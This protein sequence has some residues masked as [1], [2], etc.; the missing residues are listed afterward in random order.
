LPT[1]YVPPAVR[2]LIEERLYRQRRARIDRRVTRHRNGRPAVPNVVGIRYVTASEPDTFTARCA[3]FAFHVRPLSA[4]NADSASVNV[5]ALLNV[6]SGPSA[7]TIVVSAGMPGPW[8]RWPARNS[9]LEAVAFS[10]IRSP[11]RRSPKPDAIG[12]AVP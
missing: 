10:T 5:A 6:S 9:P 7:E 8:I 12:T 2:R 4:S 11:A 3:S 1:E